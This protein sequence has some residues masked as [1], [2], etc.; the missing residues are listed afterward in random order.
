MELQQNSLGGKT[1]PSLR[2]L[3]RRYNTI[4]TFVIMC[5]FATIAT[6]GTFF[7]G[8]NILNVVERAS[9]IGI[10]ALGQ[11][12]V[13][14]SG[15]IDL[16]VNSTMDI[17]FTSIAVLA[18]NGMSYTGAIAIALLIGLT[19]GLVNGLLVVKTN[20]PPWLVTLST[21]MIVSAI[22]LSWSGTTE[23]RFAGLQ[24]Y[25][26]NLFGMSVATSRYF[27][28]IV[29]IICGLVF[30]FVLGKTRFGMNVFMVGGGARAAH[31]SGTH[32]DLVRVLVYVISG[33]M[34]T[35]AG[36]FFA[37][38][39]GA[40]NP[41]SAEA[42]QLYSIA[43][44]VLGGANINGGEGSVFGTFF[45]AVVLAI[46]S[47]VLNIMQVN[48]YIQNAIMGLLLVLIVFVISALSNKSND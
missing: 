14:L 1:T 38:R 12:L 44:V 2:E 17:A 27:T 5:L 34:A 9:I 19:I 41:T 18:F 15:A 43:A 37:Y 32:T 29:W 13:I 45:G 42:Y 4:I 47:N 6:K 46:L 40:L 24:Q 20:I 22:A 16:S 7:T 11:G 48:I 23:I 33:L 31:L 36:I 3:L 30:A 26:N 35:L 8:T 10:V 28:G 21:M 39:V 25:I